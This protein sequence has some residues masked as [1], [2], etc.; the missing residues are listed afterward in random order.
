MNEAVTSYSP[1]GRF[2]IVCWTVAFGSVPF[3][4]HFSING[5]TQDALPLTYPAAVGCHVPR[6]KPSLVQPLSEFVV[7][8]TQSFSTLIL[9]FVISS[10]RVNVQSVKLIHVLLMLPLKPKVSSW[11]GSVKVTCIVS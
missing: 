4:V 10:S 9:S 1:L 6:A 2:V 5:A 3:P 11:Q 7:F 8:A